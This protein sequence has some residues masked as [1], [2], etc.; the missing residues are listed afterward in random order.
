MT[1]EGIALIELVEQQANTDLVCEMLAFGAGRIVE[2]E[3]EARTGAGKQ[4]IDEIVRAPLV[5]VERVGRRW[6]LVGRAR[7]RVS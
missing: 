6:R 3:V 2:V 1:D 5:L 4:P 7:F